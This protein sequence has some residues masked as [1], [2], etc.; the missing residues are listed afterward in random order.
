MR[1]QFA[2]RAGTCHGWDCLQRERSDGG[3]AGA[4]FGGLPR[5][6][7]QMVMS[8]LWR[9]LNNG[10]MTMRFMLIGGEENRVLMMISATSGMGV[11]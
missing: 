6:I 2:G 3:W 5:M 11:C 10:R 4:D 8:M 1:T 9:V 7:S